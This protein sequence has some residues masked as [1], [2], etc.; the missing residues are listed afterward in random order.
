[1]AAKRPPF[2]SVSSGRGGSDGKSVRSDGRSDGKSVRS[3]GRSDGKS[4]R[5]SGEEKRQAEILRRLFEAAPTHVKLGTTKIDNKLEPDNW[6]MPEMKA[7]TKGVTEEKIFRVRSVTITVQRTWISDNSSK[8]IRDAEMESSI[9]F[10]S[11]NDK[12]V[13]WEVVHNS[14]P[15]MR[16]PRMS[17]SDPRPSWSS[18]ET[19]RWVCE[20]LKHSLRAHLRIELILEAP[21]DVHVD[22]DCHV[23]PLGFTSHSSP[24]DKPFGH[25]F[26]S[27]EEWAECFTLDTQTVYTSLSTTLI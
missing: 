19:S 1:M 18:S 6:M 27:Q 9:Q 24:L 8:N 23:F 11:F 12:S 4:V 17:A 10:R 7:E 3:E 5:S 13:V 25:W 15:F 22:F 2:P 21:K 26:N 16:L 14:H 20:Y